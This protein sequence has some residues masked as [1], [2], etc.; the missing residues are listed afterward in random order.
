[1]MRDRKYV[2]GSRWCFW[3]W[4]ERESDNVLR[5]HVIKTPWGALCIH[6]IA[7]ADPEPFLHDHPVSF[8]SIILRGAYVEERNGGAIARC[9]FNFIRARDSH[10]IY[11]AHPATVTL[12]LMGPKVREWG[13]N[14]PDGWIF[15][16]D[17]HARAD[18]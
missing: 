7:G 15:W 4:T 6:W 12:C 8:L 5:L 10:R 17:Y 18:A 14:T 11:W 1:M 16:K 2:S 9:R 3:R 13:Y